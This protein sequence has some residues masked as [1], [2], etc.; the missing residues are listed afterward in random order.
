MQGFFPCRTRWLRSGCGWLPS[1]GPPSSLPWHACAARRGVSISKTVFRKF[2]GNKTEKR[3]FLR[4]FFLWFR[5]RNSQKP[6]LDSE[7]GDGQVVKL[8]LLRPDC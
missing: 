2:N 1:D 7:H 8:E 3:T 5:N 4:P 6:L